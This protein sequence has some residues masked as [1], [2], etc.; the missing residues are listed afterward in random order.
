MARPI[1][2]LLA[3]LILGGLSGGVP[4]RAARAL[5][6]M[7]KWDGYFALFAPDSSVPWKS[8]SVRL[9]TYSSA[10]LEFAAYAV[11]PLDVIV[12]G[13]NA[14]PRVVAT[15]HLKPVARWQFTPPT[16]Y[17]YES[18]QV[19]VPLGSREGFFIIEARRNNVAEQVWINRSRIGMLSK[20]S[21]GELLLY[22]A[23][24][25]TGRALPNM[26]VSFVV[27]N[28]FDV[29]A[30]DNHGTLAWR[31]RTRPVFALAQWGESRT[32]LSLLPS[33]PTPSSVAGVM[34]DSASVHAG[35]NLR[36]V[37]FARTRAGTHLRAASGDVRITMRLQGAEIAQTRARLDEGGSFATELPVPR[38]ARSG[39]YAIIA[40]A[41]PSTAGTTVH[42]DADAGGLSLHVEAECGAACNPDADVPV[43]IRAMRDGAPAPGV[44]VHLRAVRSP[45]L[46][47]GAPRTNAWGTTLVLDQALQTGADGVARTVIAHPSDGLA[48]TYGLQAE[49]SAAT[50]AG[51]VSVPT[52]NVALRIDASASEL[53][54]GS[55]VPFSVYGENLTDGRPAS[56]TQVRVQLVHGASIAEQ[57]LTLDDHGSA[58][59]NFSSAALGT[60]LLIARASGG[61][62]QSVDA[63][64]VQIVPQAAADPLQTRS[65][66]VQISY[67]KAAY[68]IGERIAVNAQSPGS[69]G[70]ALLT[71]E[72]SQGCDVAVVP[73]RDG[74][75]GAM[76][77]ARNAIGSVQIGAAFVRDGALAWSSSNVALDAPGRPQFAALRTDAHEYAPGSTAT[78]SVADPGAR[79]VVVRLLAGTPGGAARFDGAPDLL[80]VGQTASQDTAAPQR[81]W[82]AWVDATAT[83]APSFGFDRRES[84]PPAQLSIAQADARSL[85]WEVTREHPASFQIPMPQTRGQYTISVLEFADDG[86]VGAASSSVIV[87]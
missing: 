6:D 22:G 79:T 21:P 61:P 66:D 31:D 62:S 80:D 81:G 24:L 73:V 15:A 70:D 3:L 11:D 40:T 51:R 47:I 68:R 86:R 12:A 77:A 85:F 17:H 29:R 50:A 46:E 36:V 53:S 63:Q 16:G 35:E 27:N 2:C 4:A 69:A 72:T 78:V 67:D 55:S 26:R 64:E 37:G 14:R 18:S 65:Q 19:Q 49:S 58:R 52:S 83:R 87:R 74:R 48:S 59:G 32:F 82:H 76:F 5:L 84:A 38:S 42:V 20:E 7:H 54:A 57:T 1:R 45:H 39:D 8:A 25:G 28:R 9:D 71:Y 13:A 44:S 75:A 43:V 56:G 30:T 34:V 41:G 23:D 33:A 10:P 60:N